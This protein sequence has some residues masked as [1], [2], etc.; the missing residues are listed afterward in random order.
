MKEVVE[1]GP[2]KRT[3][4]WIRSGDVS[5]EDLGEDPAPDSNGEKESLVCTMTPSSTQKFYR[6]IA[7]QEC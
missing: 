1:L 2:T 5:R 6:G 3:E 7:L 4:E